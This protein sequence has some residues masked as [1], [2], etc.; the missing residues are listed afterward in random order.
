VCER[1]VS[2]A[3]ESIML[4]KPVIEDGEFG[5]DLRGEG[6]EFTTGDFATTKTNCIAGFP[7]RAVGDAVQQSGFFLESTPAFDIG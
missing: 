2:S 6:G 4:P 7:E 5:V 1:H 3:A